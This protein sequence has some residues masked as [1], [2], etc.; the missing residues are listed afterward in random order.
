MPK[1]GH[2]S[3]FAG[4]PVSVVAA[5]EVLRKIKKDNLLQNAS[6]NGKYLLNELRKIK[7]PS[8]LEIRGSGLMIGIELNEN[9]TPYLKKMQDLGL[10]AASSSSDTIRFL[11][12][13]CVTKK[14]IDEALVI[15]K[16][17]FS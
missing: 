4:N 6:E 12:P 17:V 5:I 3:T 7:H 13:I 16:E 14:E 9:T 1:G 8:I 2:G 11:C 10:I 15:I